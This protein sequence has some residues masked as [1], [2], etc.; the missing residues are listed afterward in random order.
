MF[1]RKKIFGLMALTAL[2]GIGSAL[3]ADACCPVDDATEKEGISVAEGFKKL[4][5][6]TGIYRF[7]NP[8]TQA[9]R[10]EVY[11]DAVIQTVEAEIAAGHFTKASNV[12]DEAR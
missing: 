12:I 9:E 6:E 8:V 7:F 10:D 1:K 11:E 3:A 4:W 5:H 2:L